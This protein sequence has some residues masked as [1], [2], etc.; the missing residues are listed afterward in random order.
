M[1][2][3]LNRDWDGKTMGRILPYFAGVGL[4]FSVIL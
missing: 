3:F 2:G 1:N 4:D